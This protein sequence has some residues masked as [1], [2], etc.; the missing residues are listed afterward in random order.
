MSCHQGRY[1][2]FRTLRLLHCYQTSLSFRFGFLGVN[3]FFK[4]YQ[5]QG[6]AERRL[7]EFAK[8]DT[9]N[10]VYKKHFKKFLRC[11]R[12]KGNHSTCD[13]SGLTIVFE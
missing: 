10:N 9:F 7:E 2:R 1:A 4:E 8:Y 5:E 11:M 12:C 6:I 13:V 3:E